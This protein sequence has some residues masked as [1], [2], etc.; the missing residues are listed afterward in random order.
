MGRYY[1]DN[2]YTPSKPKPVKDGIKAKTKQGKSFGDTWWSKKWIALLESFG[3]DTRLQRGRS[4]ARKGQVVDINIKKGI[5]TSS[6]QGSQPKPYKVRIEM[7]Q[8]SDKD[9]ERR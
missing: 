5:V 3:W 9:W 4:Y 6:V 7:K 2:Y 8:I 1:Y